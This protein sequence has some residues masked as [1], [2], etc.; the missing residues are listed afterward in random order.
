[1]PITGPL[2]TTSPDISATAPSYD[3]VGIPLE[4]GKMGEMIQ[5]RDGMI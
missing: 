1:M 3:L 2:T 5:D 4:R